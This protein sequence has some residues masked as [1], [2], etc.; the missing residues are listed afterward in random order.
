MNICMII[1][2]VIIGL[3][4]C[5]IIMC[6]I[7]IKCIIKETISQK[8]L[9]QKNY[10]LFLLMNRWVEL[11]Q[12]NINFSE[13][14]IKQGYT[15]IAIYG[16]GEV[17]QCLYKE[18]QHTS[19]KILYGIDQNA[20][21]IYSEIPVFTIQDELDKV[22]L[23]IVTPVQSFIAIKSLL[24]DKAVH[25]PIVSLEDVLREVENDL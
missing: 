19:V 4:I 18:L 10:I 17:G 9:A 14:F 7:I 5:T 15:N 12:K 3:L 25:C 8:K 22:D 20:D 21:E 16:M 13:Y 6:I 24:Q 11:K 1:S 2:R 23:V